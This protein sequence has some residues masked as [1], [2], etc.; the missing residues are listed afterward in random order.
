VLPVTLR[1]SVPSGFNLCWAAPLGTGAHFWK[2][3]CAWGKHVEVQI[4]PLHRPSA[5]ELADG[6]SRFQHLQ[7]LLAN[8]ASFRNAAHVFAEAVRD[9]MAAALHWPAVNGWSVREAHALMHELNHGGGPLSRAAIAAAA[10]EPVEVGEAETA[11]DAAASPPVAQAPLPPLP[12][13]SPAA[14]AARHRGGSGTDLFPP[15][16]AAVATPGLARTSSSPDSRLRGRC[17]SP[18]QA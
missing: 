6:A 3:M 10:G 1:Y 14:L 4:L 13:A 16:G 17:P 15:G 2:T 9:E 12:P 18:K 11:S 5:P 8:F 7:P